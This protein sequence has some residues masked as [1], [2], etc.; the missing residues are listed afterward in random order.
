MNTTDAPARLRPGP[1]FRLEQPRRCDEDSDG[2]KTRPLHCTSS[3]YPSRIAR[4]DASGPASV[5]GLRE[6]F[7]L[8]TACGPISSVQGREE[9]RHVNG[10]Y[11]S[12]RDRAG[13]RSDPRPCALAVLGASDIVRG[14]GFSSSH[15]LRGDV[16]EHDRLTAQ[17]VA[18]RA[19]A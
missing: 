15:R 8:Q 3:T 13:R 4:T 10:K 7:V 1:D 17:S 14:R 9:N 16:A 2:E 5:V 19:I 6:D 18:S 11:A 12:G